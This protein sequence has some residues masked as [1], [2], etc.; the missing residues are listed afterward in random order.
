MQLNSMLNMCIIPARAFYDKYEFHKAYNNH[1]SFMK[2]ALVA[3]L[4]KLNCLKVL[5]KASLVAVD[6]L[7][8]K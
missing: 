4:D 2:I 6:S 5:A 7:F 8:T 3:F 1:M